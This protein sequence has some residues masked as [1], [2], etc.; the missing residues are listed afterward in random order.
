MTMQNSGHPNLPPGTAN[1]LPGGTDDLPGGTDELLPSGRPIQSR[2]EVPFL[3]SSDLKALE[4]QSRR[5][6]PP[7]LQST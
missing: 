3:S 4:E 1:L 7:S 6:A 5:S 2:S